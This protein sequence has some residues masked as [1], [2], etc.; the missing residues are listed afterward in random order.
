MKYTLGVNKKDD[1]TENPPPKGRQEMQKNMLL[2]FYLTFSAAGPAL[3]RIMAAGI[4]YW[5]N[6]LDNLLTALDA[7]EALHRLIIDGI[8]SGVGNVLSFIPV[9]GVLFFCLSLLEESGYLHMMAKITDKLL[10][11]SGIPGEIT[12]PLIMGF[13]CSVPAILAVG[14]IRDERARNLALALIPFMSC[15]AKLPLYGM[16]TSV[17]FPENAGL[18]T[19]ILY[20]IGIVLAAAVATVLGKTMPVLSSRESVCRLQHLEFRLPDMKRVVSCMWENI[21]GFFRKAFT[22]ILAASAVIWFL[23][24]HGV[25]LEP[26]GSPDESL[27]AAAGKL[28]APIFA[29]LG[30]GDWRAAAALITGLSAKEAVVSTLTVMAEGVSI[31]GSTGMSLSIMLT[32]IFTPLSS[33]SFLVFCLLYAPCA[34]SMAAMAKTSGSIKHAFFTFVFQTALAWLAAFITYN[35]GKMLGSFIL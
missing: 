34:A 33:F 22:V 2:T 31:G 35:I 15:S 30:F 24:N 20:V 32:R 3:G 29:P 23:E 5:V 8:C 27:L 9:I 6:L 17:F 1:D 16:M 18:V 7:P 4:N 11:R 14:E 13:G 19:C 21:C 25:G 12:V 28:A 10:G 26:C